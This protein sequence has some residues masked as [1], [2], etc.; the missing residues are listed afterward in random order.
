MGILTHPVVRPARGRTDNVAGDVGFGGQVVGG[1]GERQI[2]VPLEGIAQVVDALDDGGDIVLVVEVR[3][4]GN[5][6]RHSTVDG[7]SAAR[8]N[9]STEVLA[10]Y[11]GT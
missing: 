10:H 8:G 7:H 4:G 2:G 9:T 3:V 1:D 5:V 11:H 6:R